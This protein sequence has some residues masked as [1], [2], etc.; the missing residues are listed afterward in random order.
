MRARIFILNILLFMGITICSAQQRPLDIEAYKRWRQVE[1]PKMSEDGK[2]ITYRYRYTYPAGHKNDV[3]VSYLYNTT[4]GRTHEFRNVKQ[5]D[6]WDHCK[7]IKYT[8]QRASQDT[9]K[10]GKD[11]VFLVSL[12][13]MKK[14]YWDRPYAC[15]VLSKSKLITSFYPIGKT[16]EGIEVKRLVLTNIETMDSTIIDSLESYRLLDDYKS[17]IYIK[18]KNGRK[19]L[20]AGAIKGKQHVIYDEPEGHLVKFS[21]DGGGKKGL[22][23]VAT[24]SIYLENPDLLYRFSVVDGSYHL[25]LDTKKVKIEGAY[26][27]KGELYTPFNQDKYIYVNVTPKVEP[28]KKEKVKADKSF[29]LELWTWDEE[30]APCRKLNVKRKSNPPKY[31]YQTD[32]KKCILVVP[33]EMDRIIKPNCEEYE[34]ILIS[35]QTPYLKTAEWKSDVTNDWFLVSLRT[36][37]RKLIF[38]DFR[39]DPVWSPN[40]K[41]ALFYHAEKKVWFKLEPETGNVTDISSGIGYPVYNEWYDRPEP[42][43]PYNIA[44]WTHGG[45]QVVLYDQYD[46]W[47]IDLTGEKAPYCLTDGWGRKNNI[48]LRLL[49]KGFNQMKDLDIRKDIMLKAVVQKTLDQGIYI[50]TANGKIKKLTEGAYNLNVNQTSEGNKYCLFTRESY[51]ESKEIWWCKSDFTRPVKV[52]DSNPQQK[53]YCWGSA[54]LVEW[55]N[56]EG[57]KNRGLLYLPENYNSSKRYPVIVNFYEIVTPKYHIYPTPTLTKAMINAIS[58]VS[59]GYVV[60]MPNIHFTVGKPGE[61]CYNAIVSGVQMLIDQGIADKDRIGVQGH[62]WSGY[63]TAYL[64]SQTNL[65]KCANAAAPVSNMVAAYTGIR[66]GSGLPRM[67]MYETGQSRIGRSLWDAPELYIQNSP[68]FYADK[69]QTPLL[70]LH[71]D[72]DEAV[73]YSEGLNLFLAMRRLQKPAWLLNY[74]GEGHV[75]EKREAVLDFTIRLKQFFDYYLK[76]TPMPRWM[77]EGIP[78]AERGVDQK[79]DYMK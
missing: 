77:K 75:L 53:E 68:I 28:G 66:T 50:R 17:I 27:L 71:C 63:Q 37:E 62:S 79:Y 48:T 2:W 59:D 7:R 29:E 13:N 49:A 38:R 43:R 54:R 64:I 21:M 9:L 3:P 6:F 26:T 10:T 69:I 25:L 72:K 16:T 39:D 58:Y 55:T 44:G 18:E 4:T 65:F 67:F 23:A 47:V 35:N 19:A 45:D 76:D 32:S 15:N 1:S 5:I 42:P 70:I 36:G 74:K 52:S 34:Y 46:P 61:S 14:V 78:A 51:S 73:P 24:D 60:F 41:Y 22:F 8:V 30:Y 11:S 20:F 56:L 12:K 33:E 40:G 31:V 57:K